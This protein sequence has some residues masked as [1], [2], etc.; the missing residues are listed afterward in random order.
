MERTKAN[1]HQA[2][3]PLSIRTRSLGIRFKVTGGK[4]A[5]TDMFGADDG[6]DGDFIERIE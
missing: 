1:S 2:G 3:Y 4:F 5:L 6:I